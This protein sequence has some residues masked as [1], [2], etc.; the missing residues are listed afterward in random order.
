MKINWSIVAASILAGVIVLII[1][2]YG[3]K[4][5]YNLQT[6]EVSSAPFF[7]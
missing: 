7:I 4:R 2:E 6:G 1:S 5:T 3:F